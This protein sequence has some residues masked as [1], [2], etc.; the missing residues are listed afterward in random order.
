MPPKQAVEGSIPFEGT[1][2]YYRFKFWS[3]VKEFLATAP[4]GAKLVGSETNT[5]KPQLYMV[6]VPNRG[7]S[8]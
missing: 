2:M 4:Q 6:F 5:H 7:D 1:I 8:Q 3:E